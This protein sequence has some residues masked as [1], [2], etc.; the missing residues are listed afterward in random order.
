M[1]PLSDLLS[2]NSAPI[3]CVPASTLQRAC[4]SGT[5]HQ[6]FLLQ[7]CSPPDSRMAS[8]LAQTAITKY[9]RLGRFRQQTFIFSRFWRIDVHI[10]V[11]ANLVSGENSLP[12]LQT[13]IFLLCPHMAF[14]QCNLTTSFNLS[15]FLRGPIF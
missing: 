9:H 2:S 5:S 6:L 10:K 4:T 8:V 11:L 15:Y 12:G 1:P 13:T 7:P 3:S 14:P